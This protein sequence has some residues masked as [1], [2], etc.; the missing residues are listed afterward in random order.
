MKT[1]ENQL[2]LEIKK[3]LEDA[4]WY[5]GQVG[6][7]IMSPKSEDIHLT[8]KDAEALISIGQD[9]SGPNSVRTNSVLAAASERYRNEVAQGNLK[10]STPG[11][12]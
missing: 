10:P 5:R 4:T 9:Q 3:R 7:L 12:Y 2:P 11:D 6:P 1:N 8:R